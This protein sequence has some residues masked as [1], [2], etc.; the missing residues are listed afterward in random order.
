MPPRALESNKRFGRQR[1]A[2]LRDEVAAEPVEA[3]RPRTRGECVDAPRPCIFVSCRHHLAIEINDKGTIRPAF[4]L[5]EDGAR[6]S[7]SL[8]VAD[9]GGITLD[10]IGQLMNISRE[11]VR[12]IEE[13]ALR[14][15]K[16]ENWKAYR[17]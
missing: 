7:C 8:D 17:D 13:V 11:R 14:R 4:P 2:L 9:K 16:G 12:Q 15:I 3:H 1:L 10:E 5:D 6:E